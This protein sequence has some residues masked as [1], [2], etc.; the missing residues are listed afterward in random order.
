[1]IEVDNVTKIYKLNKRQRQQMKTGDKQKV[2]VEQVSFTA[3]EGE[4]FGLLGPN[5]AGKT[6]TLRM[7]ATLLKPTAGNIRVQGFDTVKQGDDVRKSIA[8]LTNELK[9][10]PQFGPQYLFRFF[11]RLHGMDEEAIDKRKEELFSYFG[12]TEFQDKKVSELSTGMKQKTSIAVSL[13]HDPDVVVFDEPTNGL[14]IVTARAVTDY[15]RFLKDKGKV[16]IVSTHIMSEAQKLCDRLSM[17]IGG[18]AVFEG[19]VKQ[20]CEQTGT[21]DL[22]D[23]FFSVYRENVQNEEE[24]RE[25]K[26]LYNQ[27]NKHK[28]AGI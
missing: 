25:L 21:Q 6:T 15:L 13:L 17:I 20:V 2:A 11:G 23:A 19:T 16:I 14:D 1:M 5:G 18:R 3:K 8:F 12:I 24:R 4:I 22:E 27:L 7:I 28:E 10:D 9:L 26:E